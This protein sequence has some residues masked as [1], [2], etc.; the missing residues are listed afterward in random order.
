MVQQEVVIVSAVR[1]AIGTF[2]GSLQNVSAPT[3]GSI[4][5]KE[6]LQKAG[7]K[8]E[9]VD[10]VIMGNVLQAGLGQNPARQAALKAGLPQ[11]VAALT[12]N[13][14]CGSGLKAVHLA[15]QAIFAGDA[16]IVVAGGMEN[17]SQA[18]Y[19]LKNARNGF[20]MGDQKVVDS[21]IAD[22]LWCAF[23]D[24][25]M[26]VTAENLCEKYE[27]SRQEQDE[28]A[29]SSQQKAEKA[30]TSGRFKDEIVP[31]EIP[32]RKG[33]P[34]VFAEDEFPRKGTTAEGLGKL[35]PAFK[36]DGSVTA[37]NAS[38]I[39]DGA[40]ALVVMSREKADELGLQP[41]VRIKANASAGVDPSIM[42]IGPV[43]SVQKVLKKA[44]LE[45]D[46]FDLIEANEAFAAQSIAVDRELSFNKEKLNVNGGAISLGHP[47]G[48]SGARIL[49]SLI[50][51]MTKREANL[52]LATLCIGGGQGVATV[53]ERV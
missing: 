38:G 21:M 52:G 50:H 17:M 49:V 9:D 39:N 28:F 53:V 4:V 25:H 31:V 16:E 18:P 27:I 19:L 13:K 2:G 10:E 30:I 14:V 44:E 1:T 32:Q 20:K 5:I 51:E 8:A 40:A 33:D 48:A 43:A 26:G 45:L 35:R 29:A 15:T 12:I 46:Q 36:K 42:G 3:L 22:G 34:I 23:N 6:A 47:I 11:E 7:V 41:L 24:Y 37:G